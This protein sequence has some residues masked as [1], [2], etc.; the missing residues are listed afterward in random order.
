MSVS[1]KIHVLVAHCNPL[2]TAGLEAILAHQQDF[3]VV[4][5]DIEWSAMRLNQWAES[6]GVLVTDCETGLWLLTGERRRGWRILII[7]NDDSEASIRHAVDLGTQ[8]YLLLSATAAEIVGAVRC[9]MAGGATFEPLVS[10]KLRHGLSRDPLT[11]RETEVLR[12]VMLG[13]ADKAIA[14]VI[15]RAVGTVKAH[16]KAILGK[17]QAASRTEAV[18]VARRR[19]LVTEAALL[20]ST[21]CLNRHNIR[22]SPGMQVADANRLSGY[23]LT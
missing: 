17:L 2:V 21:S 16:V 20:A 18:A 11:P 5:A 3:A 19:G 9:A 23:P 4:C 15:D 10:A 13:L 8:G 6:Q 22:R 1:E 14:N 12:F 7:T